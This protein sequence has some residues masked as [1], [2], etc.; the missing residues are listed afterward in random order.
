M[1]FRI[2]VSE[3]VVRV[4]EVEEPLALDQPDPPKKASLKAEERVRGLVVAGRTKSEDGVVETSRWT[5]WALIM[6]AE[7]RAFGDPSMVGGRT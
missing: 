2:K 5:T 3:T 1:K 6:D 7:G 4:Y